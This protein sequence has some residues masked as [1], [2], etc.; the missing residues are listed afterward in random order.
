MGRDR[1][2]VVVGER[3][4]EK[5]DLHRPVST[6]LDPILCGVS[7]PLRARGP[8]LG[9]HPLSAEQDLGKPRE[10]RRKGGRSLSACGSRGTADHKRQWP[11]SFFFLLY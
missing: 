5:R 10:S 4:D 3:K 9:I 6:E 7:R 11:F 8:F 2:E 1:P